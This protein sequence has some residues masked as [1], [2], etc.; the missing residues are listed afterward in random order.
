MLHYTV[1][2]GDTLWTIAERCYGDGHLWQRLA[3][4]NP[5]VQSGVLYA[6]QRLDVPPCTV[7]P[8]ADIHRP[9]LP[10]RH[11]PVRVKFD[12][13][14]LIREHGGLAIH[15]FDGELTFHRHGTFHLGDFSPNRLFTY[16]LE[17]IAWAKH[18]FAD[19]LGRMRLHGSTGSYIPRN[20]VRIDFPELG[21]TIIGNLG[22][23]TQ[24]GG[25][26]IRRIE[27]WGWSWLMD[28][29]AVFGL[30]TLVLADES[31]PDVPSEPSLSLGKVIRAACPHL[32]SPAA[33]WMFA[34]DP[35]FFP[36][37]LTAPAVP[38]PESNGTMLEA[39]PPSPRQGKKTAAKPKRKKP[40]T[41]RRAPAQ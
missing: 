19:H 18:L 38:A 2:S 33:V 11:A 32:I 7:R 15:G 20:A 1:Q 34:R 40:S 5:L 29:D 16:R 8:L 21:C 9:A 3:E 28:P 24:G 36:Q 17:Q 39:S 6:G 37:V 41:A 13:S 22:V 10:V 23:W 26:S 27:C 31:V 14:P 4:A 25:E 30:A 35:S 12:G